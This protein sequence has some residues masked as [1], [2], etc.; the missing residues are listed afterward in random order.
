MGSGEE[1]EDIKVCAKCFQVPSYR[2]AEQVFRGKVLRSNLEVG[3][4]LF[5]P[6]LK[7]S[8]EV[9]INT[10]RPRVT[11]QKGKNSINPLG[12]LQIRG[13]QMVE[14]VFRV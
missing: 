13:L 10:D 7:W 3:L 11:P 2:L 12:T 4:S 8:L 14:R 5:A 6:P 1:A 9:N